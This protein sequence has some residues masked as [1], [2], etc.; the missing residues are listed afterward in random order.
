M[1]VISVLANDRLEYIAK[2]LNALGRTDGID[3][4]H[5]LFFVEPGNPATLDLI[6]RSGIRD[7]QIR[8]LPPHHVPT[9]DEVKRGIKENERIA[10]NTYFCLEQAFEQCEF[11]IHL[12]DD[13]LL[14]RDALRYFE[15]A[16]IRFQ[17]DAD[18]YAV[19]S[20]RMT[21]RT[22]GMIPA[23]A[24]RVLR[25]PDEFYPSGWATWRD[26]WEGLIKPVWDSTNPY[27]WDMTVLFRLCPLIQKKWNASFRVPEEYH[28]LF[29][30]FPFVT[31]SQNIGAMGSN[32]NFSHFPR[33]FGSDDLPGKA[34][35]RFSI[36]DCDFKVTNEDLYPAGR[37]K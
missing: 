6:E 10:E 26:R 8:E 14:C 25:M 17:A 1:K 2:M 21:P 34:A 31:R 32:C 35:C 15:W 12:E 36:A 22:E 5:V 28:R 3:E 23:N 20:Y 4:Y 7:R 24:G 9:A 13:V 37:G 19:C 29:A 27:G 11:V 18:T 16:N 30:I 33:F